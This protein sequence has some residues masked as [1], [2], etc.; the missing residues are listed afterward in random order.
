LL[1]DEAWGIRTNGKV[2]VTRYNIAYIKHAI[3]SEDNGRVLGFDNAHNY[4]HR[5]FKGQIE[6]VEF[7]SDEAT[8]ERFKNEWQEI[9]KLAGD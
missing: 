5:H 1:S 3:Y 8:L 9:V 7:I 6:A 2:T 4:H